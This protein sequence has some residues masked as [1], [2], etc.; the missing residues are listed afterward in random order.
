MAV[1]GV[2][3]DPV[4]H[5]VDGG[6]W[7][8]YMLLLLWHDCMH[9]CI[10]G[11]WQPQILVCPEHSGLPFQDFQGD[12]PQRK[13]LRKTA[14]D[15]TLHLRR[16]INTATF[17]HCYCSASGISHRSWLLP[18]EL[19]WVFN[20]Q[21]NPHTSQHFFHT[22]TCCTQIAIRMLSQWS[23]RH[24][25][26]IIAKLQHVVHMWHC[27]GDLPEMAMQQEHWQGPTHSPGMAFTKH[28]KG[29]QN[30]ILS[31]NGLHYWFG[32]GSKSWYP[33]E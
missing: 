19:S 28:Q 15:L 18:C 33:I 9:L 16:E 22:D 8:R 21:I 32:H 17:R 13:R 26:I 30:N 25:G 5:S 4:L 27:R 1:K 12:G 14:A 31:L 6:P 7:C 10:P 2:W 11:P 23:H 20:V 24:H 29:K 3:K